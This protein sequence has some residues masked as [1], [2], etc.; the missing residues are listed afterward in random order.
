MTASFHR[1]FRL[2]VLRWHR[3]VGVLLCFFIVWIA[4]TGILLNH[5]YEWRLAEKLVNNAWVRQQYALAEPHYYSLGD[6][7]GVAQ[8]ASGELYVNAQLIGACD[9]AMVGAEPV[10][11]MFAVACANKLLVVS[12][13]GALLESIGPSDGLPTPLNAVA[14]FDSQLMLHAEQWYAFDEA[15]F[16]FVPT[17]IGRAVSQPAAAIPD[18]VQ[19]RL[20]DKLD[21]KPVSW[22]R[23][24]IDMHTGAFWGDGKH[25][26]SDIAAILMML[27]AIGGVWVWLSKPGRF[28]T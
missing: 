27:I 14:S 18:H 7:S 19:Q 12:A 3:R 21:A 15:R 13:T 5:M 20:Q 9:A 25:I 2:F 22:E 23:V 11:D 10:G 4:T 17:A 16:A 6:T 28:R 24:L 8:A 1:S 26:I